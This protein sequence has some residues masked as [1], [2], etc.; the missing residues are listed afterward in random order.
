[1]RLATDAEARLLGVAG[2][3]RKEFCSGPSNQSRIQA[4]GWRSH[5]QN[6]L[7]IAALA[8]LHTLL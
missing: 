2:G 5:Q 4:D 1:M 3:Q 7:G 8:D 6:N